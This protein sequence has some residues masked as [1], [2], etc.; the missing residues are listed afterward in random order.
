MQ[1][2]QIMHPVVGEE[3]GDERVGHGFERAVR[4]REYKC[5]NPEVNERLLSLHASTR[6]KRYESRDDMKDERCDD[7][8]PVADLVHN[9]APGNDPKAKAR[10]TSS[11]DQPNLEG[12]E[13]EGA[14]PF[15]EK[16][17]AD[18]QADARRE[19]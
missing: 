13:I 8:L 2:V 14:D 6:T 18:G 3:S 19:N 1:D 4:D 12:G 17:A 9:D 10:E 7:K 16:T 11:T 5:A 15:G